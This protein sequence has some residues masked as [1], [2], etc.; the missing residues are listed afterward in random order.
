M[1]K[2]DRRRGGAA[3]AKADA[4]RVSTATLLD[5]VVVAGLPHIGELLDEKRAGQFP[6]PHLCFRRTAGDCL[7][8]FSLSWL[9]ECKHPKPVV[10]PRRH[11]AA[12]SK[13][14]RNSCQMNS[15]S[16]LATR[17]TPV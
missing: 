11:G 17:P 13:T 12:R 7:A 3:T 2:N 8:R 4:A 10:E 15:L 9:T 14:G 16:L 6:S 1:R 5:T